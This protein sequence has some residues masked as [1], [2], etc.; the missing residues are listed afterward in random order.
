MNILV[1]TST[2]PDGIE[3]WKGVFVKE[4]VDALSKEHNV[5]VVQCGID[6][7]RFKPFF[8][9]FVQQDSTFG[10]LVYRIT[11]FRSF[12][13]FNQLNYILTVYW[14]LRKIIL[15]T[16]P[17]IIHCHYS[18]PSGLVA[19]LVKRFNNIPFVVT[20]HTRIKTIFRSFFHRVL[21]I[22]AMKNAGKVIAVSNSLKSEIIAEGI[23][24]VEVIANVININ[25]FH[26][27]SRIVD[28]ITIGF[29]GSFNNKNK[30]LETLLYACENLPFRYRIKIGG[31]GQFY[32]Y[33]EKLSKDLG[34]N[35]NCTFCGNV[36][37]SEI[38]L[39]YSDLGIFVLASKYETFG[40]VLVEAMASGIPVVATKCGG[41]SDIV[42]DINGI[43]VDIDNSTQ[44]RDAIIKIYNSY[45]NYSSEQI[46][47][48]ALNNFSSNPF[49]FKINNLY[50]KCLSK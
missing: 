1:L 46:R 49:M 11:V 45:S 29:L 23:N 30:G 19:S 2:F 38:P 26:I 21:S 6:Y 4:Q 16:K 34:I 27:S 50:Q 33:Y 24:N 22:K 44:M 42:T 18:Y 10:Y 40:I 17:D 36:S 41:P 13:I 35:N 37:Q 14:K 32:D 8:K 39:F 12:P 43:L 5:N 31:S 20:E 7:N 15:L 9:G 3:N 28:P 48:F 25:K 47:E